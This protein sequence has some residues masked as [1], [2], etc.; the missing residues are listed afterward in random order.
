MS[1][2]LKY[3]SKDGKWRLWSSISDAWLTDWLTED[4]MK[5]EIAAEHVLRY[6]LSV[7]EALWTFP[8]GYYEKDTHKR[9]HNA[10][11][12]HKAFLDWLSKASQ[13]D[14]YCEQ[15]N[16]KFDEMKGQQL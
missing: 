16:K 7:I 4:E 8:Y 14:D 2:L 9:L 10:D 12:A 11:D 15:V 3:R 5:Q 1:N 6:K 13:S